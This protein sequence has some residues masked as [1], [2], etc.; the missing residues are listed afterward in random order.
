MQCKDI[1]SGKPCAWQEHHDKV[2]TS[3]KTC[4]ES[5]PNLKIHMLVHSL[6]IT[7]VHAT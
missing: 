6:N 4:P 5:K 2:A 7:D 3:T 1:T